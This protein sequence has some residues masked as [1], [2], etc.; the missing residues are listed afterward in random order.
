MY[1]KKISEWKTSLPERKNNDKKFI[2]KVLC[3]SAL[4]KHKH[5]CCSELKMRIYCLIPPPTSPWMAVVV[6]LCAGQEPPRRRRTRCHCRHRC[7]LH[8]ETKIFVD[9]GTHSGNEPWH[10]HRP[11]HYL[12]GGAQGPSLHAQASQRRIQSAFA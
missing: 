4:C 11:P 9:G 2:F 1:H 6:P 10:V 7:K 8:T 3:D 12:W 5:I